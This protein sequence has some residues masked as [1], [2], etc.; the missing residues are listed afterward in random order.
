MKRII[1][2]ITAATGHLAEK[3]IDNARLEVEL[4]L[5]SA[6][7]L[8]RLD[9]Y[10][11]FDRPLPEEDLEK[12]RNMCRRRLAHEPLQYIIGSTG[13][14]EIEVKTDRRALIP[15]PETELLVE[16]AVRYLREIDNPLV[17]DIGTGTGII[18][19]SIAYEVK[20][21][22]VVAVDISDDALAL[23]RHN[24]IQAGVDDRVRFVAGDMLH[25]LDG[26]GHFDAILS[27]PPYVRSGDIEGLDPEVNGFEPRQ[28]LDGGLNG[29]RFLDVIASDAHKALKPVGLLMLE[30]A[31]DQAGDIASTAKST[32]QYSGIEILTDLAG[33]RRLVQALKTSDD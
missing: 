29:L 15:R 23:A 28:A 4:M 30:C 22:Q 18:A 17:A 9:L 14:R 8:S 21:S 20:G 32:G 19:I 33:K 26:L 11:A 3:G 12:F 2:I 27:N 16:H 7:G 5:G 6:L 31:D 1:D 10:M 25:A 24:A 13:F